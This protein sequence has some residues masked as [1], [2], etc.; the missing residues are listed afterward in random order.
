[1]RANVVSG[2]FSVLVTVAGSSALAQ[3]AGVPVPDAAGNFTTS[4]VTGN[5]GE[6]A[7]RKWLVIDSDGGLSCRATTGAEAPVVVKL[8][9]GSILDVAETAGNAIQTAS[10]KTWLEV[11]A[12]LV[13][14][15]ERVTSEVQDSYTCFVRASSENIAPI[16]T[17]DDAQ[18]SD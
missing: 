14:V 1:M 12:E 3:S 8:R 7:Q 2:L 6:Y 11:R 17:S 15:Q 13:D 4:M 5:A 18:C 9:F 10:G 16:N